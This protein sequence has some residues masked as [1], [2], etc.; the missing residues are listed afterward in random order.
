MC[1]DYDCPEGYANVHGTIGD[2]EEECCETTCEG[3][4][5]PVG[6]T[7]NADLVG[8][9]R[10]NV[11]CCSDWCGDFQCPE[12]Y[13]SK[14]PGYDLA[15][16]P[17][18]C[19][20]ECECN[21][22]ASCVQGSHK[23]D[24]CLPGY[25]L[26]PISE[27]CQ[28]CGTENC[29]SCDEDWSR[30]DSCE[31]GHVNCPDEGTCTPCSNPN[32][33][34]CT[35]DLV[36]CLTCPPGSTLNPYTSDCDPCEA[37]NCST[38]CADPGKCDSCLDGYELDSEAGT[39]TP[40]ACAAPHCEVCSDDCESQCLSC[41]D[42]YHLDDGR[43]VA[44]ADKRC[45]KC[46]LDLEV[47]EQCESNHAL[48]HTGTCVPCNATT[49]CL[50]CS[51]DTTKCDSCPLGF[52][53]NFFEGTCQACTSS[54]CRTCHESISKCDSCYPG[55]VFNPTTGVCMAE[56]PMPLNGQCTG[57]PGPYCLAGTGN[58]GGK[59][60]WF[61]CDLAKA[62]VF[63][64]YQAVINE[65]K[66]VKDYFT[67]NERGD[68]NCG[69]KISTEVD[70]V[71]HDTDLADCYEIKNFTTHT[72]TTTD[73]TRTTTTCGSTDYSTTFGEF[74]ASDPPD[75]IL[76]E[77][78]EHQNKFT[79]TLAGIEAARTAGELEQLKFPE[80]GQT[81]TGN[82]LEELKVDSLTPTDMLEFGWW[83]RK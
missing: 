82:Q 22:C 37:A 83:A 50:T 21:G 62:G 80:V 66:C 18:E 53:L 15:P 59:I 19:C 51:E 40:V 28:P 2:T 74:Y 6:K 76:V 7:V 10:N 57:I 46:A 4:C 61:D 71:I 72:T 68:Q 81:V 34:S 11:S 1:C 44:C 41:E 63:S 33:S 20:E 8:V 39:C 43:C 55:F 78:D 67:Y 48:E 52:K 77:G 65:P 70:L 13:R 23:C 31:P 9:G 12:G 29:L 49:T 42:G 60:H 58:C 75:P 17:N 73:N 3:Y 32:C 36:T 30:C 47:C 27:M 25:R 69:C 35:S 14:G 45:G 56:E 16:G 64:C 79:W 5:C 24:K 38:C 26:N 54:S